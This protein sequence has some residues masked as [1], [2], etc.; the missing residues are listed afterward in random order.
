MIKFH[1]RY[2]FTAILFL[3]IIFYFF[4]DSGKTGK[5]DINI[6]NSSYIDGLKVISKKDG[7][8]SWILVAGKAL[9]TKDETLA[10]MN[11]VT[12]KLIKD[13]ILLNADTGT[14]NMAT[15]ELSLNKNIKIH[16]NGSVIAAKNLLWNPSEGTLTTDDGIKMD[17]RKFQIESKGMTATQDR[18]VKL[19]GKVKATFY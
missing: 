15:N 9:F 6:K 18:K 5:N 14:F 13:G 3:L 7:T 2:L 19:T 11:A 4:Y 12:V 1:V 8:D 10:E 16:I 17:S